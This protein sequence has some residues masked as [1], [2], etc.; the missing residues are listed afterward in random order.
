MR[1]TILFI[2][3]SAILLTACGAQ[4]DNAE[5]DD[6][7][8]IAVTTTFLYDMVSVLEEDVDHFKLELIIPA[9]ED[10][11]VYQPK[12]SDLRKINESDF[13]LYQGLNLDRKSTRLNSSHVAI[14]YAVFCL[15]K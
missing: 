2:V 8:Q 9:G 12:A 10:P 4:E 7:I 11:H 14:S 6:R 15:K 13:I 3:V 5:T 1:K